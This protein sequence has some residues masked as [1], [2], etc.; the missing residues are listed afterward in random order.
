VHDHAMVRQVAAYRTNT[1]A[2]AL[3]LIPPILNAHYV[4]RAG[5][6]PYP[7]SFEEVARKLTEE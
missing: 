5:K 1:L 4:V 7:A 3:A 6:G 2:K